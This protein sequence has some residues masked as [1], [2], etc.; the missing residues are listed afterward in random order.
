MKG[1]WLFSES[2]TKY[3]AGVLAPDVGACRSFQEGI[4]NL[5]DMRCEHMIWGVGL[6]VC[7]GKRLGPGRLLAEGFTKEEAESEE[8]RQRFK[9]EYDAYVAI[10]ETSEDWKWRNK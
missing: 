1:A 10:D 3:K 8:K 6:K 9:M 5:G 7:L 2:L 4:E